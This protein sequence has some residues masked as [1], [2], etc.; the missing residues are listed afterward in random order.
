M[1]PVQSQSGRS[2]PLKRNKR[3]QQSVENHEI[4]KDFYFLFL[5]EDMDKHKEEQTH[6]NQTHPGHSLYPEV[7]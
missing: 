2:G 7:C 4:S 3:F 1:H 6:D 5:K